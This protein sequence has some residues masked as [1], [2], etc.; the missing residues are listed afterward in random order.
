MTPLLI[1]TMGILLM[2]LAT[3]IIA[4]SCLP[5]LPAEA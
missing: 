2:I 4:A 1:D 5:E 3:G